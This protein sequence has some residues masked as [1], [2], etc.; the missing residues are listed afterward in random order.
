MPFAAGN[1]RASS[2]R[3]SPVE[4]IC[5]ASRSTRRAGT[6]GDRELG[7]EPHRA[8]GLAQAAVELPVL[9]ALDGLVEE[10]DALERRAAEHAEVH[11]LGR[12]LVRRRRGTPSRRGRPSWCTRARP[13]CSNGVSPRASMMPPTL[14]APGALEHARPRRARSRPAASSASRRARPPGTA[15][16]GCRCSGRRASSRPRSRARARARRG[17]RGRRRARRCRRSTGRAR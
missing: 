5:R 9:A 3:Q 10:A 17:R 12:A 1:R 16:R 7:R 13:R 8:A 2:P 6:V 4:N 15:P 11:G 14:S